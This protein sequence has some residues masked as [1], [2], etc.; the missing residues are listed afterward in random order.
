[1]QAVIMAAGKS[2]RTYPLTSTRPK[3]LI[4]VWGRPF[5]ELQLRQLQ[6]VVEDVILVVGYRREQI[7]G[8]FGDRFQD[9]PL[10][11]A[12]Q[13]TQRGTADALLTARP[14]VRGKVLA[15]N[16]DDFYHH[17]DLKALAA[18]GRG[19]LVTQARDPQ[20]RAVVDIADGSVVNIV[21]KPKNPPSDAWCSVGGYVM[22]SADLELLDDL[23]LSPRGEL[24]LPDFILR[25]V[26]RSQVTPQ[27]IHEWWLPL[28]YAWDVLTAT[29]EL[30]SVPERAQSLGLASETAANGPLWIGRDVEI[31]Q[32]VRIVGPT[33]LGDGAALGDGCVVERCTI[34][35]GARVGAGCRVQ[36][37]VLGEDAILGAGATLESRPGHELRVNVKGSTVTPELDRLGSIVGDG[38]RIEADARVPAGSLLSNAP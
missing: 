24:E 16:G 35:P 5:L 4:P 13:A 8:W 15:L 23:P 10:R 34:L 28:T 6:G 37:S 21:E 38:V 25:V 11:Y 20:N 31:G 36:D 3:P 9:L 32:N 30:W 27:R 19:L 7:E 18:R 33:A 2:T 29:H 22:E 12:V 14:L 17:N 26:R 1:M